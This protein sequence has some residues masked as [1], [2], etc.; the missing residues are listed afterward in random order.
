[1]T[2]IKRIALTAR[3]AAVAAMLCLWTAAPVRAQAPSHPNLNAQLLVG[4]RQADIALVERTLAQGAAPN[5]RNRLGKTALLIASEKGEVAIAERL[6]K[7]GTDVNQA[8]LEGVTPL[9][10]ASY[11]GHS[12]LVKR[13]LEAGA[14]TD[15]I[16]RM[17]KPAIV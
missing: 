5:S 17:N 6:L 8:S 3:R 4:A 11:G 1:M 9:M 16:D 12:A 7:A 10:A 2:R 15:A 14:R 13:L